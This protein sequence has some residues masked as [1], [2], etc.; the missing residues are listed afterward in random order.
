M[1]DSPDEVPDSALVWLDH[2][3]A[4]WLHTEADRHYGGD[5][6]KALNDTV[7]VVMAAVERPNDPWAAVVKQSELRRNATMTNPPA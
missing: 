5:V 6:S 1:S 4:V 3:V 7:R 2:D